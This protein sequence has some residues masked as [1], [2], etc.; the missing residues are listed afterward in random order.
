MTSQHPHPRRRRIGLHH[1]VRLSG[2]CPHRRAGRLTIGHQRA[3]DIETQPLDGANVRVVGAFNGTGN[4][5]GALLGRAAAQCARRGHSAI[6][7]PFTD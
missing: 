1:G 4:V 7:D 2:Q 3:Q 5:V 6:A